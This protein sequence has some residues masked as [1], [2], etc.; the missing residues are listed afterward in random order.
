MGNGQRLVGPILGILPAGTGIRYV[1]RLVDKSNERQA[2]IISRYARYAGGAEI[3]AHIRHP[4]Y[5]LHR[6]TFTGPLFSLM[7]GLPTLSQ[8]LA[9]VGGTGRP[10][11]GRRWDTQPAKGARIRLG[12]GR[13]P[14]PP[15]TRTRTMEERNRGGRLHRREHPHTNAT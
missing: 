13:H 6:Q 1:S 12:I 8:H 2:Q 11:P 3:P 14:R 7:H 5:L 15:K 9:R 10:G 4:H